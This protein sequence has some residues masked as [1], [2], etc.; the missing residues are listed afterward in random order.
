MVKPVAQLSCWVDG[1]LPEGSKPPEGFHVNK[2]LDEKASHRNSQLFFDLPLFPGRSITVG[3]D[4]HENDISINNP[5]VSRKHLVIYLVVYDL[6]DIQNQS[7]LI[8]VRDCQS[9]AGTYVDEVCIGNKDK[10]AS[11]GFYLSRDVIITI[12]PHWR[13]RVSFLDHH[14]IKSPLTAIQLKESSL[15]NHR[16]IISNRI[17]GSG[18]FASV[19]LA[20]DANTGRQ[21]ACKIHDLDHLCRF[22]QPQDLIRRIVDETDILGKLRH[23]N[24]PTFVYAFRSKH[25][26]YTFT[27]LATGGDLFSMRL[28]RGVFTEG[29]SKLVILQIVNAIRYLHEGKIAHRD[30]KPENVLFAT[31]PHA[32]GRIIVGDLG[33]AKSAASGRMVSRVDSEVDYGQKHGHGLAVDIWSLGMIAVFLL[34]P[35]HHVAPTG[36]MKMSQEAIDDWLDTVFEDPYHQDTTHNCQDFIRSCLMYEPDRRIEAAEAKHHPWFEQQSDR[37]DFKFHMRENTETWKPVHFISPPVQELPDLENTSNVTSQLKEQENIP[38]LS[39]PTTES[40]KRK[41]MGATPSTSNSHESPY[42]VG[43]RLGGP[44]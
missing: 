21:L 8:Y 39:S 30:L 4:H 28:V 27:E 31:G 18:A 34:A 38:R 33:F 29:E 7:P 44:K 20:V 12:K 40:D 37:R 13:F 32:T 25:T 17:L 41:P 5:Y 15:F 2:S 35:D 26:L 16:Y 10:G 42:F 1:N 22:P 14:E 24:F 36:F 11:P 43:S 3:R 19:H 23:P 9:L 6:N